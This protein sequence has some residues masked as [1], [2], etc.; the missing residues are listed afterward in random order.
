[1]SE[2]R[3]VGLE[4]DNLLGFLALL[5]LLRALEKERPNWFPRAFFSGVPLEARLVITANATDEEIAVAASNGCASLAS[6]FSFGEY[7]DLTFEGGTAR[8][9]LL[10]AIDN[11]ISAE[12]FSALCSDAAVKGI[13][14]ERVDATPLCAV[15]GQ[16]HQSFLDRL[17]TVSNGTLPR[18]L[19]GKNPPDLNDPA[20]IRRALFSAWTRSDATE[21]F[22]WDFQED[23]RYAL[24][25]TNPSNDAATTEHGANRLA[26]CGLM[27]FQSAPTVNERAGRVQLSTRGVSRGAKDRRPRITWPVWT[28]PAAL[29]TIHALLDDPEFSKDEPS[30]AVLRLNGIDQARRVMRLMSGKFISFSRATALI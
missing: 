25:A 15:F 19:K 26:V 17:Q 12:I 10:S 13:K 4:T 20:F 9:L 22:R 24:R 30:F 18:A 3:L 28:A 14:E 1:M 27:S 11:Q 6:F 16:G 5:G 7:S 8:K 23:R 2:H 21:S 29:E